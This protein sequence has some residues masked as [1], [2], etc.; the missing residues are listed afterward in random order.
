MTQ[1]NAARAI[2]IDR[3]LFEPERPEI[4]IGLSV[5]VGDI[6]TAIMESNE[7]V[8]KLMAA[9]NHS[10]LT[11]MRDA[12]VEVERMAQKANVLAAV[13]ERKIAELQNKDTRVRT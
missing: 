9:R 8:V 12:C 13:L 5:Y 4:P 10:H 6:Q 1:Y 3:E 7:A 2:P 11:A